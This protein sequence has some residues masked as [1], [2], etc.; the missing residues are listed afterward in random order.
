VS[1]SP[2]DHILLF[3]DAILSYNGRYRDA[4]NFNALRHF[5]DEVRPKV[6]WRGSAASL[7]L[8]NVRHLTT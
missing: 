7:S 6:L 4:W 2:P 1:S 3:Q 8:S 5:L